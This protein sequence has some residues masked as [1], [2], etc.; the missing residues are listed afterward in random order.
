MLWLGIKQPTHDHK[1]APQ[2]TQDPKWNILSC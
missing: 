2:E 1:Q